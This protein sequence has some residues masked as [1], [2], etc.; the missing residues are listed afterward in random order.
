MFRMPS[1]CCTVVTHNEQVR[2]VELSFVD[3]QEKTSPCSLAA[4]APYCKSEGAGI[5]RL[6]CKVLF[7]LFEMLYLGH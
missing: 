6:I 2:N 3:S 5:V 4:P 1:S 7:Y